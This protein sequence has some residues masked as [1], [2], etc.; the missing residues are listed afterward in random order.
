[1]VNADQ[2]DLC[3]TTNKRIFSIKEQGQKVTNCFKVNA[4][5]PANV[6]DES[7]IQQKEKTENEEQRMEKR[8]FLIGAN[9]LYAFSC[10]YHFPN[11]SVC[12]II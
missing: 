1:M 6:F 11:G 2:K 10:R 3:L 8:S 7:V 9:F 5:E 12:I 4:N